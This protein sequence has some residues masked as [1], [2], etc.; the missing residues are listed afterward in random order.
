MAFSSQYFAPH[1]HLESVRPSTNNVPSRDRDANGAD[2][3]ES[4]TPAATL[5]DINPEDLSEEH[6]H[7][8]VVIEF[9]TEISAVVSP[10][11]VKY[12]TLLVDIMQPDGPEDLLDSLQI[13][14]IEE[15][16]NAKKVAHVSGKI[17]DL[18][19]KLPRADIR[20]LHSSNL[21]S[22]D[23]SQEEQDQYDL[24]ISQVDL[25]MRSTQDEKEMD[26]GKINDS[27]VSFLLRVKSVE[28]SASERLST[29]QQ[30]QAAFMAQI[31]DVVVSL[32]TKDVQSLDVDVGSVLGSTA[33]GKLEY[34]AS[35]IHRTGV[36]IEEMSDL[37]GSISSRKLDRLAF[38]THQ[39]LREGY[40]T[41]DPFFLSR[42]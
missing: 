14:S 3:A 7:T 11:A 4:P 35:L 2:D 37:F 17:T 28:L 29:L 25:M 21:D 33:S 26:D 22:P 16:F 24:L 30:P 13:D 8:S 38:F 15:I 31:E 34:L 23:P 39:V 20:L 1:F 5:E 12:A 42:S 18:M 19:V 9:P 36:V 10:T 41:N 40:S 6:A 32:G 27:R